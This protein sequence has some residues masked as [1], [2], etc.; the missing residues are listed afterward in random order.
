MKL[1]ALINHQVAGTG[2]F[3]EHV[4]QLGHDLEEWVPSEGPP[5]RALDDY[6]AV[7]AFGGGMQAD[8]EDR[9]PWLT[10]A[11]GV[12]SEAIERSVPTLGV[13]LGGQMLARAA[14]GAVGP[15]PLPECGWEAVE[16]TDEG[17]LDPLFAGSP[18]VFDVFQWHSYAF[19]LPPG[20]VLLAQN[21]VCLQSFRVGACAWG[22]QWHPEVTAESVALWSERYVPAPDGV[23]AAVDR[24]ALLAEAAT[25]IEATNDEGRELCA[26]FLEVAA[27]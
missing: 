9:H 1:L 19:D 13:C 22:L 14:G 8:Q 11:L 4:R 17:T 3:G 23:P 24:E 20:A 27:A 26:R 6:G 15:S 12:L 7:M 2:V 16:L 21:S 10:P 5:P 18:R 25:R